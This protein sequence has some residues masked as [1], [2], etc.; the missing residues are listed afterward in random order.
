MPQQTVDPAQQAKLRQMIATHGPAPSGAPSGTPMSA[1]GPS[2]GSQV[3]AMAQVRQAT[4]LLEQALPA[5]GADTPVGRSILNAIKSLSAK[6]PEN[7]T[8]AGAD[9]TVLRD[10]AQRAA[11]QAPVMALKR[12]VASRGA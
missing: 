8:T 11:Q 5:L 6:A 4:K 12:A 1:P 10:M 7:K 2:Q 9:A 3:Q